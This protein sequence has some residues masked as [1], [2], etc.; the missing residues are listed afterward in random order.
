MLKKAADNILGHTD[1]VVNIS[2][3]K[4]KDISVV[5]DSLSFL[6][7]KE[8]PLLFLRAKTKEFVFTDK[9]LVYLE[10]DNATGTISA[11]PA[12]ALRYTQLRLCSMTQT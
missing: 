11:G 4:F 8:K 6:L 12:Y 7:E 2:Q 10:R 5:A 3:D 9:A 1:D